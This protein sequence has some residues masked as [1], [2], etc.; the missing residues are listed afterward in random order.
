MP[1]PCGDNMIQVDGRDN[2]SL[3]PNNC[4]PLT[5]VLLQARLQMLVQVRPHAP[6][7]GRCPLRPQS[8]QT[9]SRLHL[10]PGAVHARLPLQHGVCTSP[11]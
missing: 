11:Q 4:H 5:N 9:L 2:T 10:A 3:L 1:F 7:H 8:R 6:W